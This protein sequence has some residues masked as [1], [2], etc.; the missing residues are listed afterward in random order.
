MMYGP[1]AM[2]AYEDEQLKA[3]SLPIKSIKKEANCAGLRD[4]DDITYTLTVHIGFDTFRVPASPTETILT[5]MER[6]GLSVPSKCR[7]GG[8]GFC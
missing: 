5:A 4:V 8:C 3:F 6:A 2:Y 1:Q 7:A